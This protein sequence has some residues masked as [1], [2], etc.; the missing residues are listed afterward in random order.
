[1][2]EKS[3]SVSS[4]IGMF[5]LVII[6]FLL[7]TASI[8]YGAATSTII[9]IPIGIIGEIVWLFLSVGLFTLQPNESCVLILFG[10]YHGT[11][12]KSGFHWANPLYTKKKI[13]LRSR[14]LNGDKLKV[15][16]EMG[17][18][19]E[20]AAVVVWRVEDTFKAMFDVNSYTDYVAVQSESALRHL[21]GL[22]PYDTGEDETGLSLRGSGAE[23][24]EALR[25]E[26]QERLAKAGVVI[27]EARI[28]HLAYAPEIA[29]A[30]LQ[31]QQANA[32]IAAR[33]KI[34]EG[35]VTMVD[36]AL[37]KLQKENIVKLDDKEKAA[38]V[39]NLLVVLC[40]EKSTQPTIN[41]GK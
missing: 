22:Y 35:A 21:A 5:V 14:N 16:D 19:I 33:Q 29:A 23:V 40:S 20:I 10:D 12:K 38:M 27:E 15:N 17:N 2:S 7:S 9:L 4:G 30:M 1:M 3:K 39:S 41:S 37:E 36:M 18:P 13:S 31:R 28:S 8:I 25:N 32:I 11:V 24:S 26:L 6:L 34:V